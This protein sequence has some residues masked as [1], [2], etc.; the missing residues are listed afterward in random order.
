VFAPMS[1]CDEDPEDT[2]SYTNVNP[3]VGLIA[4]YAGASL[5]QAQLGY[6]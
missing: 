1:G 2:I 6:P 4:V 3:K 5:E